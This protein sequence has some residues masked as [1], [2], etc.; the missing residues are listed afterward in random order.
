MTHC[1][2]KLGTPTPAGSLPKR[3]HQWSNRGR[4]QS[5]DDLAGIP[6]RSSSASQRAVRYVRRG[7]ACVVIQCVTGATAFRPTKLRGSD[8]GLFVATHRIRAG[9]NGIL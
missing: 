8:G 2:F 6:S 9:L 3:P 1:E 4:L 5:R 7:F